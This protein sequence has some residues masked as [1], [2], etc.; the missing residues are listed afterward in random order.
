VVIERIFTQMS[1]RL[2]GHEHHGDHGDVLLSRPRN[3]PDRA[4]HEEKS[5]IEAD[6]RMVSHF[7]AGHYSRPW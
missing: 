3:R 7:E 4:M 5:P 6:N 2:R 1:C